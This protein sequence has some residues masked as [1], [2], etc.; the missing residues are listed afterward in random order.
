MITV[1]TDHPVALDSDDHLHPDGVHLDNHCDSTFVSSV[2]NFFS[3]AKISILDLGCAGGAFV[4]HMINRG[5][6]V[7]GLEGSDHCLNLDPKVITKIGS[8][9][10]GYNNWR[11]YGNK[12][13]FTCDVSY[14]YQV[15]KH[16]KPMRFDLITCFDVMEHL[17]P[18]RIDK[19]LE[20]VT[21][22]LKPQGIFAA[23]IALF[24]LIKNKILE[25]G[26][27]DYHKAIFTE[28]EWLHMINPRLKQVAYPFTGTYRGAAVAQ[29]DLNLSYAGMLL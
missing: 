22:H 20:M 28:P 6:E 19:F 9:P 1:I 27:V 23:N 15:Q 10:L 14:D 29:G 4:S 13:L 17:Y 25:P 12:N 26:I 21:R 18:E 16:G 11:L 2:E 24:P 3:N 7:V 5:H 8:M